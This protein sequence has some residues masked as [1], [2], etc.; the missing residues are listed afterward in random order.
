MAVTIF[1]VEEVL[2][3][4][5]CPHGSALPSV[6]ALSTGGAQ[7]KGGV[8]PPLMQPY[9]FPLSELGSCVPACVTMGSTPGRS[10]PRE[11]QAGLTALPTGP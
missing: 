7:T 11:P 3:P 1:S 8:V 6:C 2:P 5:M 4:T 10:K 9:A